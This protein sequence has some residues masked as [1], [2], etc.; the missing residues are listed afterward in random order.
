MDIQEGS[1]DYN[2]PV[3]TPGKGESAVYRGSFTKVIP[4]L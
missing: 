4:T 1:G 2:I 3:T